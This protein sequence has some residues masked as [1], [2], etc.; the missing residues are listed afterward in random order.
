MRRYTGGTADFERIVTNGYVI[1]D[2]TGLMYQMVKENTFVFL[3]RPRRFGKSLL[4]SMLQCYFEGRRELFEHYAI[5]QLETEWKQHP[6]FR[7][8]MSMCKCMQD[9]SSFKEAIWSQVT[10]YEERYGVKAVGSTPGLRLRSLISRAYKQIGLRAVVIIDEYDAPILHAG[11]SGLSETEIR[12]VLQ[13][14]YQQIKICDAY[15]QFVFI[16]GITKFSNLSIFSAINNL[17]NLTMDSKY[18]TIC[19]ITQR[20]LESTF[21]WDV[22]QLAEKNGMDYDTMLA[23]LR[24]MYDGYHFTESQEENIYNPFSLTSAFM[25]GSLKYHWFD[26][27][28]PTYLMQRLKVFNTDIASLNRMEI[29]SS[30]FDVPLDG[31]KTILP[32]LYQS[33]YLTIKDYD[34]DLRLYVLD[35][36]NAEVRSG[37]MDCVLTS[38]FEVGEQNA[39]GLAQRVYLSFRD[40][41]PDEAMQYLR[42]YF[43]GVG[44]L[45]QGNAELQDIA[46]YE[47]YYQSLFTAVFGVFNSRI[48]TEVQTAKGR[49]DVVFHLPGATFVM[50]LKMCNTKRSAARAAGDALKQIDEMGYATP[51]EQPGHRVVRIGAA[52]ARDSRTIER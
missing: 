26:T 4:C 34:R 22:E 6:V 25:D 8:D 37:F 43:A 28:T 52:F 50:E 27:A 40:D 13:E 19:G 39:P 21:K 30:Q 1:S 31:M 51:Y 16:T 35:F 3:S 41:K 49:A 46:K 5:V 20:E 32:L 44:N 17:R 48:T 45:N 23:E 36:P 47:A 11:E 29:D 9:M 42:A 14:F 12:S 38:I 7:F 10:E 33:G 18:A 15:E 24:R 2:K